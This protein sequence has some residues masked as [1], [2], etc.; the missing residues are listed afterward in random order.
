MQGGG[1][2]VTQGPF[3]T[4]S[5]LVPPSSEGMRTTLPETAGTCWPAQSHVSGG[6]RLIGE[7]LPIAGLVGGRAPLPE[8]Q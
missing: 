5:A 3:P 7:G 8:P 4:E 6:M 2:G 1:L